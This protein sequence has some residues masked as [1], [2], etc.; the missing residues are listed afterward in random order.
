MEELIIYLFII[1][2]LNFV[3]SKTNYLIDFS[4]KGISNHKTFVNLNNKVPITGGIF[5][6]IAAFYI[7][8]FSNIYFLIFLFLIFLLGILSDIE[9]LNS[10][11]KRL[12][13]QFI[14]I[15][16]FVMINFDFTII[17]R[18]KLLDFLLDNF[19]IEKLFLCFCILI[20]LNGYNFIDGVNL[21]TSLNFLIIL[22]IISNFDKSFADFYYLEKLIKFSIVF[23]IL[24][25][26]NKN[27]LG[28]GGSYLIAFYLA[29]ILISLHNK[30]L[31]T[32][33]PYFICNLLWYP[34]FENL[35]S[36]IRRVLIKKKKTNADNQHLH[37]YIFLFLKNKINIK[38]NYLASSF[39]GILINLYLLIGYYIGLNYFSK[40]N[41]QLSIIFFNTVLYLTFYYFLNSKINKLE[42]S[43][44]KSK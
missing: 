31:E 19:L 15:F 25:F 8:T 7:N 29:F 2:I 10:P 18:I 44:N 41:V 30:F 24:N 13:F 14:I 36:I 1:L 5:F 26:F 17:T 33:S 21:L 42:Y 9:I 40:T 39:T 12:F 23:C 34:A 43:K 22:I 3:F 35:F 37:H 16:I 4:N 20:I 11:K 32:M 6:I 27:F 28:D 38:K